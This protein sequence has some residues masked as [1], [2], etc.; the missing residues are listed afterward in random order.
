MVLKGL[1]NLIGVYIVGLLITAAWP[2]DIAT[3]EARLPLAGNS[4]M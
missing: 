1:W 4:V 3:V 2:G